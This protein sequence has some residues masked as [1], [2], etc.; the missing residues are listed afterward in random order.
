MQNIPQHLTF[1]NF[2]IF[3]QQHLKCLFS[4]KNALCGIENA[5][6]YSNPNFLKIK[7]LKF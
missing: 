3:T 2:R 7:M 1:E 5:F 6:L 4:V